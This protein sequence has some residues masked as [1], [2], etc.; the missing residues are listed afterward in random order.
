MGL[1]SA[2]FDGGA[3][4][5]VS[6]DGV[7]MLSSGAPDQVA[8]Y[9]AKHAGLLYM[10]LSGPLG[11]GF[12]LSCCFALSTFSLAWRKLA[13]AKKHGSSLIV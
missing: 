5:V 7:P 13:G 4:G 12:L 10:R 8:V 2:H 1:R 9:D 3:L 11:A 6:P